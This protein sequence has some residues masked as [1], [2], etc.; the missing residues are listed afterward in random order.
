MNLTVEQLV[1]EAIKA[2]ST[3]QPNLACLYIR[4]ALVLLD[5]ARTR[6]VI[7]TVLDVMA[8]IVDRIEEFICGVVDSV[9]RVFSFIAEVTQ[10]DYALVGEA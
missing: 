7:V 2:F 5:E 6:V 4:K 10:G 8:K 3:G 9:A 1:E